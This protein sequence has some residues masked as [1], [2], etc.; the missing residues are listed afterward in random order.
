[1]RSMELLWYEFDECQIRRQ[2]EYRVLREH[3]SLEIACDKAWLLFAVLNNF[4]HLPGR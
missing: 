2:L 3:T 4:A 1:M